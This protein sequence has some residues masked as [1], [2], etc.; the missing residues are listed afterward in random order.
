MAWLANWMF[1][2]TRWL[3]HA[4]IIVFKGNA[5]KEVM[6]MTQWNAE[7]LFRPPTPISYAH[8]NF[9]VLTISRG[10]TSD[11]MQIMFMRGI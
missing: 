3:Q 9:I 1:F 6:L 5:N 4:L 10:L 7:K 11:R 8:E 2:G